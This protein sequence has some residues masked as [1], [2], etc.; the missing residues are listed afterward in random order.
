MASVWPLTDLDCYIGYF[1]DIGRF[2][3]GHDPCAGQQPY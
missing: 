2:V 1:V 3:F